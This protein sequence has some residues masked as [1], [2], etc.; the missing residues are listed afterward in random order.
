MTSTALPMLRRE[1]LREAL[2]ACV[3]SLHRRRAS[4]IPEGFIE[5][6]VQLNWLEWHGGDLRLTTTGEN[7]CRQL[8]LRMPRVQ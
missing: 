8:A 2:Q 1:M 5:D 6:Y 4:E 7:I 3:A